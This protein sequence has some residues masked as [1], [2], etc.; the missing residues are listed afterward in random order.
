MERRGARAGEIC[1]EDSR[2]RAHGGAERGASPPSDRPRLGGGS[3]TDSDRREEL[4]LRDRKATRKP[5]LYKVLLHNDDFTT[6][7]FVI[8]VLVRYFR[9]SRVEATRIMLE[10][11]HRGLG[12]AGVFTYEVAETKVAQVTAEA[13]QHGMPL[14]CT[15]EAA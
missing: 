7:D 6:M 14:K 5:Q 12:V 15:V 11:H 4:A 3:A 9:K 2:G 1:A 13:R 10:V 8:E